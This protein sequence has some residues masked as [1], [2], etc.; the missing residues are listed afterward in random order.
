MSLILS[1]DVELNPGPEMC[2]KECKH[3]GKFS[4]EMIR[5][6]ACAIWFRETCVGITTE[7]E[8]GTWPCPE[9]RQTGTR[10][11]SL[12]ETLRKLTDVAES[13]NVKVEKL[14][15]EKKGRHG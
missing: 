10:V 5:C 4:G 6:C 14:D 7:D 9:C 2:T 1:G 11:K 13:Q 3:K 12:S 15:R 8:R